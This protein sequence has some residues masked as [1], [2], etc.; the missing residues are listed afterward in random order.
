MPTSV[1]N[2]VERRIQTLIVSVVSGVVSLAIPF[3]SYLL[4]FVTRLRCRVFFLFSP[5]LLRDL[6]ASHFGVSHCFYYIL[7]GVQGINYHLRFSSSIII[8]IINIII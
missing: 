2:G 6:G 4:K 5:S 8:I 7:Y 3:W 1:S